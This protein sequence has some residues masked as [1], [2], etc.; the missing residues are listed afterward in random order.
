MEENF[1]FNNAALEIMKTFGK[2]LLDSTNKTNAK[3]Q[4]MRTLYR[5]QQVINKF[6]QL[7]TTHEDEAFSEL[8]RDIRERRFGKK[9]ENQSS[10]NVMKNKSQGTI[11]IRRAMQ[12]EYSKQLSSENRCDI[13][14]ETAVEKARQAAKQ[15][16]IQAA[17]MKVRNDDDEDMMIKHE[18]DIVI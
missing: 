10:Q 9:T 1:Q 8:R 4:R 12:E 7:Q 5:G 17:G 13:A 6:Q 18:E 11:G 14:F 16:A 15:L 2:G 3:Q